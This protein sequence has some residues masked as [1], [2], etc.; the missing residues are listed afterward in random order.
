MIVVGVNS[1][2]RIS[3]PQET[4]MARGKSYTEIA[5]SSQ[6]TTVTFKLNKQRKPTTNKPFLLDFDYK[7]MA[8]YLQAFRPYKTV[9]F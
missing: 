8:S 6:A 7:E 2:V 3:C 4:F 9:I 5:V 1:N